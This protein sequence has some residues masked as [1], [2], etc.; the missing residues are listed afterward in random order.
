[1]SDD[2]L[3][4]KQVLETHSPDGLELDVRP[5]LLIVEDILSR[6]TLS[7]DTLADGTTVAHM[8]NMDE[9]THHASFVAMMDALSFTI[10]RICCES[11][12]LVAQKDELLC[13][14]IAF[15]Q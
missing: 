5:L 7:V 2:N 10:D 8:E 6:A 14:S 3:M 1:M 15:R 4:M 9:K 13:C 12:L 11:I